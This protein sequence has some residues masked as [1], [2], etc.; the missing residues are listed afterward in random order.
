MSPAAARVVLLTGATGFVGKVVLEELLRRREELGIARV[1]VLVRASDAEHADARLRADVISSA[2]FAAHAAG[3]EKGVEAVA[4]DVE[5]ERLGLAPGAFARVTA[6]VTHVIHCAASVEFDLPLG[7]AASVNVGGALNV[8]E[9][10]RVCPRLAS[11]VSV[12]TAYV[13]PHAEP[14]SGRVARVA[15]T[16]APLPRPAREIHGEILAARGDAARLLTETGH[17]NTYTLTKCV[18]EHLLAERAQDLPLTLV[19]P[20]IVSA[21]R[22]RPAPGWIDSAAAFAGF[23]ALIGSGRL[24]VVAG[25]P[26][27]KLDVVPCDEVAARVAD[28]C[29][30]PPARGALRIRHAVAG[31]AGALPIPLCRER[32]VAYFQRHPVRG[33]R[34]YLAFVGPRGKRFH[35]AQTLFHVMPALGGALLLGLRRDAGQARSVRRL[36]ERQLET[37]RDFAYFTHA[38]FDFATSV[39]LDPP[40]EPAHYL[41]VVCEGVSR[42]LLRRERRRERLRASASR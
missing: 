10:S 27:A 25:D 26:R 8:L 19:R 11:L 39:P 36:L 35:V 41:D 9:L 16:L 12:S 4:G 7:E 30:D 22:A 34:A 33:E 1:L 14:G 13:T 2:C 3:F 6:E 38:T 20:S 32:I 15:E 18:A 23:V 37:N 29:F 40:L 31:A 5:R 21:S 42:N 28:A 17:P 24:R